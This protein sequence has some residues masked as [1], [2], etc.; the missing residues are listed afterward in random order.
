MIKIMQ[1]SNNFHLFSV[2]TAKSF[3]ETVQ[4]FKH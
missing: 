2:Q 3:V 1:E 4:Y